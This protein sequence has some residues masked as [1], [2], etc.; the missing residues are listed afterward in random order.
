MRRALT[1][2]A[3]AAVA[4][5]TAL[6]P[7]AAA[8]SVTVNCDSGGSQFVCTVGYSGASNATIRWYLNGS[9]LPWL[10]DTSSTGRISC[11]GGQ[12]FTVSA[13]VT[14]ANGPATGSASYYC[15]P[16]DWP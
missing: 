5:A 8:S 16:G 6:S 12:G 13:T 7:A 14:D 9:A 15:N 2:L 11:T 3:L 4:V 10:N 1:P